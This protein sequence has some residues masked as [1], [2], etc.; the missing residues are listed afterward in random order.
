[1]VAG[2]VAFERQHGFA[3]GLSFADAAVEVGARLRLVFGAMSAIVDVEALRS[4]GRPLLVSATVTSMPRSR[5]AL[6]CAWRRAFGACEA[7]RSWATSRLATA[8]RST[9]NYQPRTVGTV[10]ASSRTC[11]VPS[12]RQTSTFSRPAAR[13]W[14]C[15]EPLR[16]RSDLH[17]RTGDVH[18]GAETSSRF[19]SV[20]DDPDRVGTASRSGRA[21]HRPGRARPEST[22][23]GDEVPPRGSRQGH[24]RATAW[25]PLCPPPSREHPRGAARA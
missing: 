4:K 12:P 15:E 25:L 6:A 7:T 9:P 10:T 14:H 23:T 3:R 8:S 16:V 22:P 2:E 24:S 20:S 21:G 11:L 19:R 18:H 17:G 13:W 1:M 5:A